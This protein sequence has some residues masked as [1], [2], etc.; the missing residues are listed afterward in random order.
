MQHMGVEKLQAI[1]VELDRAPGMA[2]RQV[3][4]IVGQLLLG[5]I[6]DLI[7]EIVADAPDRPRISLN[8]LGLK[9]LQPQVL[10][11]RCLLTLEMAV[12][13]C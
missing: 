5:Q 7:R 9:S 11:M 1:P 10:Q 13:R 8:G 2:L 12:G 6:L 4:E 3:G